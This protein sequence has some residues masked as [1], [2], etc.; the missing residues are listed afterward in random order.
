VACV[1]GRGLPGGSTARRLGHS[2]TRLSCGEL[3]AVA[4]AAGL[5]GAPAQQGACCR[6]WEYFVVNRSIQSRFNMTRMLVDAN[7][8]GLDV[9]GEWRAKRLRR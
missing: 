6:S 1:L 3:V 9:L 7:R 2:G 5:Q 8:V 4:P